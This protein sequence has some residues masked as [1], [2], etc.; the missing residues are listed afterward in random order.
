MMKESIWRGKNRKGKSYPALEGAL[1]AEVVIVGAGITGLTAAYKLSLAGVKV[2]VIEALDVG[3]GTTGHSSCHLTTESDNNYTRIIKDFGKETAKIVADSRMHAI[4]FIEKLDKKHGIDCN[5][6]RVGG[7]LYAE[8]GQS[9]EELEAEARASLDAGLPVDLL[10]SIPGFMPVKKAVYYPLEARFDSQTYLD[11]LVKIVELKGGLVFERSRVTDIS[12]ADGRVSVKTE[13]GEVVANKVIQATHLP[14]FVDIYQTLAAP[15]RSYMLT[16]EL[17]GDFPDALF[18]D[19]AEPYNYLRIAEYEGRQVLVVGGKDHKTGHVEDTEACY[20]AL[21]DYARE[22]FQVG[23]VLFKWSSQY[24]EPSDGLPYIGKDPMLD[25]CYIA[26]GFSGDGL[27]YGTVSG[28][29]LSDMILGVE[30][31]WLKVYDS[32]RFTPGA[33][34]KEFLK[35]NFDVASHLVADRFKVQDF[36][37]DA[38]RP[39]EG[40]IMRCNGDALAVSK[41]QAGELHVV[42]AECTHMNCH[43][44]WNNAET[45]WDCPCHGSRFT[46][47]GKRIVGPAVTDLKPKEI[48]VEANAEESGI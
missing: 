3:A 21:E 12:S 22:R 34:A 29:L 19:M 18:W 30:N 31:H 40:K 35:E 39:G 36:N 45:S 32:Q 47:D 14:L 37:P 6:S 46:P 23:E 33:S 8:E 41:D 4:D 20:Q 27:V 17:Q 9:V 25:N 13:N 2:A 1:E 24:Y 15:Y 48:C 10:D 7:Y 5:F 28:I 42:S 11:E 44:H 16:F 43:V 26:T 38:L